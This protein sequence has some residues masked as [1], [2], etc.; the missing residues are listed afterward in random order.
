[1]NKPSCWPYLLFV[2]RKLLRS[3]EHFLLF[4]LIF[5]L[6]FNSTASGA[7]IKNL[8]KLFIENKGQVKNEKGNAADNVLFYLQGEEMQIFVTTK[9]YSIVTAESQTDNT[10]YNKIDFALENASL[11]KEQ[12]IFVNGNFPTVHFYHAQNALEDVQTSNTVIVKN[13]YAGIDW[14]WAF[15]KDKNPKHEFMVNLGADA[16]VIQYSV[17][18]AEAKLSGNNI[19]YSN[20]NMRVQ[21]GP[22]MLQYHN[23][24]F[25]GEID[26]QNNRVGFKIP[27][28]LRAGGFTIDPPLQLLYGA[29]LDTLHTSFKSITPDSSYNT[30]TVGYSSDYAVPTFPQVS[31]SYAI[32]PSRKTDLVIMKTDWNQ[33][34]T[35]ATFFGGADAD[36]ANSVTASP[37]G[38]FITGVSASWDFP[39]ATYGNF[40]RPVQLFG[41]DAFIAKFDNEGKWIWSTGYGGASYDEGM[42]IKYHN[43]K[44]YV[45]GFTQ[46]DT[47]PTLQK[48]GA[49]FYQNSSLAENDAFLLE[50]DTLG[51]R[52]W[53][54]CFGGSGDD[55]FTSLATD[56]SGIY[57]TGFSENITG[58]SIPLQSLGSSYFQNTFQQAESFVTRFSTAGALEWSSY[59][60]GNANEY[61]SSVIKNDCG[62][63]IC[64]YTDSAGLPVQ[65]QLN[66]NYYQP[67]YAGGNRDGFIAKFDVD[68]L[69]KLYCTFYGTSGD[70]VLTKMASDTNCNTI[71]TGFTN[72]AIPLVGHPFYFVQDFSKGGYEGLM[73]GLN[74]N[75]IPFW[76]TYFG[77]TGNDFGYDLWFPH[78]HLVDMVGEGFYNYGKDT[79]GGTYVNQACTDILYCPHVT[80]N[81]VSNRFL[82]AD[83]LYLH[84]GEPFPGNGG[85]GG[86][87]CNRILQF[88]ALIPL[89]NSCPNQCNGI[90]EIDTANIGGC[91]P[92]QFVWSSGGTALTD[93]NLC[94]FYW[95]TVIDSAG[96]TRTIYGRFDVFRFDY[97]LPIESFC[98]NTQLDWDSLIHMKGGGPPY[99]IIYRGVTQDSCPN[100]AFFDL[101]DTA[102][103]IISKSLPWFQYNLD[104][105]INLQVGND[106]ELYANLSFP[107]GTCPNFPDSTMLVIYDEVDTFNI[108]F[109]SASEGLNSLD[110]EVIPGRHYTGQIE[111][112]D[113][114]V[115]VNGVYNLDEI[116]DTITKTLACNDSSGSISITVFADT[117]A[118]Q[119]TINY[120]VSISIQGD[121]TGTA[122]YHSL[123]FSSV[124]S[125]TYSFTNLPADNYQVKVYYGNSCD[126]I[127][128][129][130]D[131]RTVDFHFNSPDV[132][133]GNTDTLTAIITGGFA[134]FNF[135]WSPPAANSVSIVV[136]D[137][138]TY[139]LTVTD[140][141]SCVAS[142]SV[143]VPGSSE[144]QID[145]LIEN[146]TPCAPGL[147][148]SATVFFSGG[149]NPRFI[150][151]SNGESTATAT[152]LPQGTNWV[153]VFDLNGCEAI[154]TFQNTKQLPFTVSDS[155]ENASC[156][157]FNDGSISLF[158][159][160]GYPNYLV[161]W[162]SGDSGL[163]VDSLEAGD[164]AY[165]ITDAQG[166]VDS[167][168]ITI[169]E[170]DSIR[171]FAITSAASC[172]GN[173]GV[174]NI[175]IITSGSFS[176]NWTPDNN[177]DFFR[178]D[179]SAGVHDF[180]ITNN[181]TGCTQPGSV[182]IAQADSLY[183]DTLQTDSTSCSASDGYAA[184]SVV[185]GTT[186]YTVNWS[187]GGSGLSRND[188]SAGI[189]S[190][191]I[192]DVSGCQ[193]IDSVTIEEGNPMEVNLTVSNISCFG[194]TDGSASVSVINALTPI[195]YSWST[196][197]S[198]TAISD[199]P[200]G[201]YSLTVT[202]NRN[203]VSINP[204]Q[205]IEPAT[206]VANADTGNGILC[207]GDSIPVLIYGSG[208]T[209]PYSNTNDLYGAGTYTEI[210]TDARGCSASVTFTLLQPN[211][212]TANISVVQPTCISD[213]SATITASGGALPYHAWNGNID[214]GI[215]TSSITIDDS[216]L[217]DGNNSI[218]VFDSLGCVVNL[219]AFVNS[220]GIPDG[221]V[222]LT[223]P[224]CNGDSNGSITISMYRGVSPFTIQGISFVSSITFSN[225]P[226]GVY[227]YVVT[228]SLGCTATIMD[229]LNDPPLLTASYAQLQN[230]NCHGDSVQI[231]FVASGGTPPYSGDDTLLFPA[232]NFINTITDLNGCIASVSFSLTQP[233]SLVGNVS[234]V[235]P[236]C[237]TSG[238]VTISASGG[239]APYH[240]WYDSVDLGIFTSSITTAP[241]P[242]NNSI[243]IYD[244]LGCI[245]NL[246]AVVNSVVLP[247]GFATSSNLLCNGDSGSAQIIMTQGARPFTTQNIAF[248]DTL[249]L[250]NLPAGN[251]SYV[252][253]DAVGCEVTITFTINEPAPLVAN[254]D[255]LQNFICDDDSVLVV[256]YGTGGTPPYS[257]DGTHWF[258]AGTHIHTITDTNGCVADTTFTLI[259]PPPF[260]VDTFITPPDCNTP[261]SVIFD[262]NGGVGPYTI[263]DKSAIV[264][265]D[266]T[267]LTLFSGNYTYT[268]SDSF[269]CSKNIS[270]SLAPVTVVEGIIAVQ[271]VSCN[272]DS[273]GSVT[274]VMQ[275]GI[276]PFVVNGISFTDS[277]T[278]S[279]LPAGTYQY[280]I[281]D[282]NNCVTVLSARV[283]EP[284]ALVIDSLNLLNGITC[285]G[286]NDASI[287]VI[288]SGGT[289]PY[290]YILIT[291]DEDTLPQSGNIFT[292]LSPGLYTAIVIDANGCITTDTITIDDFVPSNYRLEQD[293]ISCNG[294]NDGAIK[295]YAEPADRNPF[296]YS[297]N[298]GTP[299][300]YD[301]FYGLA[302]GNYEIVITDKN[303][304]R[305]TLFTSLTEPDSI[306]ARVWL[307]GELL[308]L[309]SLNIDERGFADFTKQNRHLWQIE[310]SPELQT[311]VHLDSLIRVAPDENASYTVRVYFDSLHPDCFVEY[312]GLIIIRDVPGLP[313]IIT[314]NGDGFN[315]TWEVD[316]EEFPNPEIIIFDRWG[317][318][319]YESD[320]YS[321]NWDGR[322]DGE[323]IAD[324][325][326]FYLM[327]VAAH[328][329]KIYKGNI[330]VLNSSR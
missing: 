318:I 176:I 291:P 272:G 193:L 167:N 18:G 283:T 198:Q 87:G 330:N 140:A 279:N 202:D 309:D 108:P 35:W 289:P 139:S 40:T 212:F 60:G 313:N 130:I 240:A 302:A 27:P 41:S 100:T 56:N 298:G 98:S 31:G 320:D 233:D 195:T 9:G 74:A 25:P 224:L 156:Y 229:T 275:Q 79:I 55:Y 197:D 238:S 91:P 177:T 329:G 20:E 141:Q 312:I 160:G 301:V 107:T 327:T 65:S 101:S 135:Q 307:N 188:L 241:I 54:T 300:L 273:T 184:I 76:T 323:Y 227:T 168:S 15:D 259:A 181:T 277:I 171:Y 317:E 137:S 225:L 47:F 132:S 125:Q 136:S 215:F 39:Q 276:P 208:G 231:A 146:I 80:S 14:V 12:V 308:P 138:G 13:I 248:T 268:V 266:T 209:P 251:Y 38:I 158:V 145:S 92:Y 242:G 118:I 237:D 194:E 178:N 163:Q 21:E 271:P 2:L 84:P 99:T 207:F 10:V 72:R 257:G 250:L 205:I 228:D 256:F 170:P 328:G 144:L 284:E 45:A 210:I 42:D 311:L 287:Q 282:T 4:P 66:G 64:G 68:S 319:I 172:S 30:I 89:Q 161:N 239:T 95:S 165:T 58:N 49:Y 314:P 254:Y 246:T 71:A 151:W 88:Q 179:L 169:T 63:F 149:A 11:R 303:N 1:M 110:L 221:D 325:T 315:D 185:G 264:F 203:C 162:S 5:I 180:T 8:A 109:G 26:V 219:S 285:Y 96:Q 85:G 236:G 62:I 164:Y 220:S 120:N 252:I 153:R 214:L 131:L 37:S 292:D 6:I 112:P 232:G 128:H 43:G 53:A 182:N 113:C 134:P 17:S 305:D 52:L 297:L 129:N 159:T 175:T 206:F 262:A 83:T 154:D 249:D 226:A 258:P 86:S 82:N 70:D 121:S 192:T 243:Q 265:S 50:F 244:S 111:L 299:Q 93:S 274:I 97:A 201:N 48:P 105:Q 296:A 67:N 90:A 142:Y 122:D 73:L 173:D 115:Q 267:S 295:I 322:Y 255:I 106:C 75:Q 290:T 213:A 278:F 57:L 270:F 7:D 281:I 116:Q 36:I 247:N 103:C 316:L 152:H 288:A 174:A 217:G 211:T 24:D 294:E 119:D 46:S 32:Y 200:A 147:L 150:A 59:F 28:H 155:S 269:G 223:N 69:Q 261:G 190:F 230:F 77:S 148:S 234:I 3:R 310:F 186:P 123:S 102:G 187:D 304:C 166:C 44:I 114:E 263:H 260:S 126:T 204:F 94:E 61:A 51:N 33:N 34:L 293:S 104:M 143:H 245:V 286:L 81:G 124:S 326:Y 19:I 280:T 253:T 218:Q 189:H 22:V 23:E 127:F 157:G 216:L 321:N 191:T 324:G 78:P 196:G 183:I 199:L 16:S 222:Y 133:C 306:D 29:L 235:Q 117:V